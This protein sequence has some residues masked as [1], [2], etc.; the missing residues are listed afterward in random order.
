MFRT[1][2]VSGCMIL[3]LG[4]ALP[5]FGQTV[6]TDQGSISGIQTTDGMVPL[7]TSIRL[8]EPKWKA[9]HNTTQPDQFAVQ[10]MRD[11]KKQTVSSAMDGI[12]FEQIVTET[13]KSSNRILTVLYADSTRWIEGAFFCIELPGEYYAKGTVEIGDERVSVA[14]LRVKEP[15]KSTVY[16]SDLIRVKGDGCSLELQFRSEISAF[17][18]KEASGNTVVYIS[19]TYGKLLMKDNSIQFNF[20]MQASGGIDLPVE[21]VA[22]AGSEAAAQPTTE[23]AANKPQEATAEAAKNTPARRTERA[24][25]YAISNAADG[26]SQTEVMAWANITGI[27]VH[28]ELMAF[29]SSL[30]LADPDWKTVHA[31]GKERQSYPLYTRSGKQQ[32]VV[33]AIKKIRFEQVVTD[34]QAGRNEVSIA[35]RADTALQTEGAYFCLELPGERYAQGAVTFNNTRVALGEV[36]DEDPEKAPR[37]RGN[38]IQIDGTGRSLKL[39]FRSSVTAFVRKEPAGHAVL[40]IALLNGRSFSKG[41]SAQCRFSMQATGDIDNERVE[42][43]IDRTLPGRQF[44]G[45]GGNFR[46]QNPRQDPKVIDYCLDNMRVAWGRVEMPWRNWQPDEQADPLAD[47]QSGRIDAR[48]EAAM[49]MAQRLKALGMP[50]IVSAWFPPVWAIAGDPASYK[51]QG[52]V[53]AYR[54]DPRKKQRIYK[55]LTDY[56]VYLK[57]A[58]GVEAA[59]YSFNESDLGIDVVHSPVE[60]A[61]FIKELGAYMASRGLATKV[62]LGDNSDAT[63]FDFIVP[64]MNDPETYPYIGAVSFHSWRGCDD[65][66]LHKWAEASRKLNVPLIVGEGSTDAAAWR[67]PQIFGESTFALYEINLYMRICAICQPQSILQWQLTSDYSILLGDGIFGTDGPL[68]RTQRYWNLK[69]L[70]ATPEQSF[71]LPFTCTKGQVNCAAFGNIARGE[72]AVHLV[73]NGAARPAV[74]KGLPEKTGD[75]KVYVTTSDKGMEEVKNVVLSR[76][77]VTFELP[78]A[79]FATVIALP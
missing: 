73:N 18:C 2:A 31:T 79:S 25:G 3:A 45:L 52:G 58:Y 54:L 9:V 44:D 24:G 74:V 77:T 78:A 14:D 10:Y 57:Q 26:E 32:T 68:R 33:T 8:V 30:R 47:A 13:G 62:L 36:T 11:G 56:L 75:V 34:T 61:V 64:A 37:Y 51:S 49:Q 27:R 38:R 63:T 16:D 59:M 7:A 41:M 46:L 76:G 20:T 66:A 55:S 23:P 22:E 19:L 65:A 35:V 40:Y 21:P 1:L 70:A 42:V 28:G 6:L 5:A 39:E 50:V 17:V 60:H 71:A 67:Y 29:E 69:Q 43:A 4:Q 48:V 72:Y 53:Q 12:R 15:K